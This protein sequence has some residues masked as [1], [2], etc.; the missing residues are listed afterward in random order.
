MKLA[1]RIRHSSETV[2]ILK[3]RPR[4]S[5]CPD[6][7]GKCPSRV[8]GKQHV[9]R[10]NKAIERR[11]LAHGPRLVVAISID[12]IDPSD[13]D[14]VDQGYGDGPCHMKHA[15]VDIRIYVEGVGEGRF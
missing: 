13:S 8:Q 9:V 10:N 7:A 12:A 3:S 1:K 5:D 6:H 4:M 2:I 11:C 15:V 14:G